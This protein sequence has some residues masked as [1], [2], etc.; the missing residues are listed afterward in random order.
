L[1]VFLLPGSL[2]RAPARTP[3]LR[4]LLS[5]LLRPA[6]GLTAW[7]LVT[8]AWHV[9]AAYD[10]A[11]RH[12]TVHDLEHLSFIVAGL[13]VWMQIVDPARRRHLR[14]EQR[15]GFMLGLVGAGGL[16]AA[17]LGLAPVALYPAYAAEP[18]RLFG[19]SPLQDQ[20]LAAAM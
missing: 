6:V 14:P 3:W 5:F 13:L 18:A 9:P 20:Q 7:M 12:Q 11:L 17:V 16:L 19:L 1:L 8:A 4:R 10:Y 15:L 2:L